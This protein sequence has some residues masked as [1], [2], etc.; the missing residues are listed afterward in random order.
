MVLL[1]EEDPEKREQLTEQWRDHKL[2]ELSF[3]GIVVRMLRAKR[4][5]SRTADCC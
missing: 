2:N 5:L 1:N 4:L 3:I